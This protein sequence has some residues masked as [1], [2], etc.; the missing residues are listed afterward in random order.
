MA[1]VQSIRWPQELAEFK[2]S[3]A[4]AFVHSV[5]AGTSRCAACHKAFTAADTAALTVDVFVPTGAPQGD[6]V[7]LA[8]R[9]E[10]FVCHD[11]CKEPELRVIP[12]DM[13]GCATETESTWL[14]FE[15]RSASVSDGDAYAGIAFTH[16]RSATVHVAGGERISVY[17]NEL[18]SAGFRLSTAATLL[19]V[20]GTAESVT[21]GTHYTL[22]KT[23]RFFINA[24]MAEGVTP[25][26]GGADLDP[27]DP[28]DASWMQAAH[29]SEIL[30][31][32]GEGIEIEPTSGHLDFSAAARLGSLVTGWVPR[33]RR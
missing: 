4:Q 28:T 32:T 12:D 5:V 3:E 14:R 13:Q 22:D 6:L 8:Y 9:T 25:L 33:G 20:L 17:I 31:I 15:F 16:S 30:V 1:N 29:G 11:S 27:T 7:G 26:I 23:G 2:G 19:E 21:T 18:L 24:V 10:T